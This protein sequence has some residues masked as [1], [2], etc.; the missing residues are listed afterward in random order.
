VYVSQIRVLRVSTTERILAIFF[1][2]KSL[3]HMKNDIKARVYKK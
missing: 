2:N 1:V 3:V